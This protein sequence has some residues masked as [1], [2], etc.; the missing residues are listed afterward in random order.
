MTL[1]VNLVLGTILAF[2]L[3]WHYRHFGQTHSNRNELAQVFPLIVLVTTLI[4]SVVKSSL[5]LSLG[6]V[7]ALSIVRFRTP[8]KEPEELAYLFMALAIGLGFGADQ[9]IAT[10]VAAVFIMAVLIVRSRMKKKTND[11][12]NLYFNVDVPEYNGDQQV[13]RK[14][15]GILTQHTSMAD[16]RRLDV[17]DGVL[18]ATYFIDCQDSENLISLMDGLNGSLPGVAASFV[19]RKGIPGA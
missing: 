9:R 17:R 4:I 2:A 15:N 12:H 8:I 18:Q 11:D 10:V 16:L 5:A 14:I 7:G 3:A 13:F 19:E 6:L 1:L